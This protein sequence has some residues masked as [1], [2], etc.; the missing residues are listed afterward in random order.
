VRAAAATMAIGIVSGVAW[1][2][3]DAVVVDGSFAPELLALLLAE[4]ERAL[5][6]R[7]WEGMWRPTVLAGNIGTDARALGGAILPMQACFG[8]DRDLFLKDSDGL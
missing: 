1:L 3:V 6:R 4:L 2:D 5:E 8:P 7:D